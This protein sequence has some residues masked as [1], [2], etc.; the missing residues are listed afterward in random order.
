MLRVAGIEC[1]GKVRAMTKEWYDKL[2]SIHFW[3]SRRSVKKE[4][5]AVRW[6]ERFNELVAFNEEVCQLHF[7]VLIYM[8]T[9]LTSRFLINMSNTVT[10][11]FR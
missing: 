10:S 9:C 8:K 7:W 4:D 2:A 1:K 11:V 3:D 6:N 5:E